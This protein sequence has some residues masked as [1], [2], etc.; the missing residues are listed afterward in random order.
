VVDGSTLHV[1]YRDWAGGI[2]DLW[3][4]G[5]WHGQQLNGGGCTQAPPAA[6]DPVSLVPPSNWEYVSYVDIFGHAQLLSHFLDN[7]WQATRLDG[8]GR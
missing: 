3:F 8:Q 1:A 7:P 6:S 2:Q 4:D 5:A